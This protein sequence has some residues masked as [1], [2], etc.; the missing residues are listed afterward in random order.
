[1]T[2]LLHASRFRKGCVCVRAVVVPVARGPLL[3]WVP[4]SE[5]KHLKRQPD[6]R[7]HISFL[8]MYK[9]PFCTCF[10]FAICKHLV[11]KGDGPADKAPFLEEAAFAQP[12]RTVP[13]PRSSVSISQ[14]LLAFSEFVACSYASTERNVRR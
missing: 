10:H 4:S 14:S 11:A 6:F 3:P 7:Q 8:R 12:T 5:T 13:L 1:M 2:L 9:I